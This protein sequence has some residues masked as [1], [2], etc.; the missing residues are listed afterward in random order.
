LLSTAAVDRKSLRVGYSIAAPRTTISVAVATSDDHYF[1]DST[2]DN[3]STTVGFSLSRS[4]SMRLRFGVSFD[5][6]SREFKSSTLTG[7]DDRERTTSAWVNR[8]LSRRLGIAFALTHYQR[9]GTQASNEDRYE[10]RLR[11]NP[12]TS[13]DTAAPFVVR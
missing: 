4:V 3:T 11:Y 7:G 5:S 8:S 1:G 6:L 2:L 9:Q 10:V 12:A 13:G